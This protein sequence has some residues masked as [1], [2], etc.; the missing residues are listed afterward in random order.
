[1]SLNYLLGALFTDPDVGDDHAGLRDLANNLGRRAATARTGARSVDQQFDTE[2]W[3]HLVDTGLHRITST[4][5]SAAGPIESAVALHALARHSAAVP[6]AETDLLGAWLARMAGLDTP[7]EVPLTVAVADDYREDGRNLAGTANGVPWASDAT[8]LLAVPTRDHLMV[9]VADGVVLGGRNLAGEPRGSL[10]FDLP[11][12]GFVA[13][14]RRVLAELTRRGA[15][16]RCVQIVGAL[17]TAA[18]LSAAHARSRSQFGRPLTQFQSVQHSL[19]HLA[20][21][22]ERARSATTLAIAAAAAHGFDSVE[23]DHSVTVAKVTLGQV[24]PTV[25]T[26]A[27]QLHGAIGVTL[28]HDLWM[29]TMRARSWIDEFGRTTDYAVKLGRLVLDASRLPAGP[30]DAV[31]GVHPSVIG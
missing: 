16:A 18:Q 15:W 29:S 14:D 6:I 13:L 1:M 8:V 20:G 23:A 31:F 12:A 10:P 22:T 25:T 24:V 2:L 19:A 7:E 11:R 17:D 26:I 3:R 21:E 5:D 9:T 27:H 30:W 4:E 28:E